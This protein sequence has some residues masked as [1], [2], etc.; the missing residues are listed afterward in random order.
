LV[1]KIDVSLR[2]PYDLKTTHQGFAAPRLGT[3]AL[4][5]PAES[6]RCWILDFALWPYSSKPTRTAPAKLT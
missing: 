2:R 4:P 1:V 3:S 6:S 5:K